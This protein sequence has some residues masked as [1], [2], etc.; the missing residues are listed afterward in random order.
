MDPSLF[1]KNDKDGNP[2]FIIREISLFCDKCKGTGN[3]HKCI[4]HIPDAPPWK[5][6]EDE[7]EVAKVFYGTDRQIALDAEIRGLVVDTESSN[8]AST[9]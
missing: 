7:V 3:E 2:L 6:E 1:N 4:H 9:E 8:S 5:T